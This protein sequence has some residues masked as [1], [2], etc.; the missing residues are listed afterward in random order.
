MNIA[1]VAV[2]YNR[3]DSLSRL[4]ASLEKATYDKEEVTLIISIDK[5]NTD[6]VEVFADNYKWPHGNKIVSKHEENLG[7]RAHM[8]SL[9]KWFDQYDALVVLEDDIVVSP[10]FYRY[11]CQTVEKYHTCPDVAGISLY[12]FN[13]NYETGN[14]FMPMKDEYDVYFMNCAMSWGEIWMKES[15]PLFYDWYYSHT[16]FPELSHLPQSICRWNNKS[17]LK[18]HTRYCI[19]ENKYFVHPY[20]SLSTNFSDVGEHWQSYENTV[21]Q[22]PLQ[23]GNMENFRLPDFG[24]EGI[25]YDGFFENKAL[26]EVLGLCE[27][28]V[29][30]D[31]QGESKNRINK[32]YWLTSKKADFKVIKSFGLNFRP[33]ELN[34]IMNN[35]GNRLFL[36]DTHIREKN[37]L[38]VSSKEKLYYYHINN[39]FLFIRQYGIKNLWSDICD[40]LYL[41]FKR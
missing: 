13:M 39:M 16:D 17:W 29:C 12:G 23:Q 33:I 25:Y 22:V 21:F 40:Y 7:L 35:G 26:Y 9:G 3:V 8:L 10:V 31:L 14:P 24:I 20:T 38:R 2:A 32:R 11:T 5:S 15:W 6:V 1:I 18:Y 41:K 4:L 28:E 34:V 36:Y 37:G 19:E 27:N 30:L